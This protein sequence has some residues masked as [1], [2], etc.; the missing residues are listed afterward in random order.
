[1]DNNDKHTNWIF[2]C[3]PQQYHLHEYF[4]NSD[5]E[6]SIEELKAIIESKK[7]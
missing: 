1:M 6:L 3:N 2:P 5:R 7:K 4:L